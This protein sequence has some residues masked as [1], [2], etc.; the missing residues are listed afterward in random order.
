MTKLTNHWCQLYN[1]QRNYIDVHPNGI[2]PVFANDV[3][4]AMHSFVMNGILLIQCFVYKVRIGYFAPCEADWSDG[5]YT[6]RLSFN[7][8]LSLSPSRMYSFVPQAAP[9]L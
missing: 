4:C 9:R 5:F 8:A 6:P 2:I 1:I 3:L 7:C